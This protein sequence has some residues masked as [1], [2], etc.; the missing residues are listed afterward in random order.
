MEKLL[1]SHYFNI[2]DFPFKELFE[3]NEHVWEA[4][5]KIPAFMEEFFATHQTSDGK[6]IYIGKGTVIEEGVHIK[7]PV[8]IG[9]NCE[10]RHGAYI[11]ENTIIGNNVTVHHGCEIKQSIMLNGSFAPHVG[12]IGD[13]II[14]NNVN[15]GVGAKLTNLRLDK[16]EIH[17]SHHSGKIPTGLQKFGA[18]VGDDSAIGANVVLN[19]GTILGKNTI[20]Y[21]SLVIKGVHKDGEVIQ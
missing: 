10:I 5:K 18:I 11:R 2:S 7:G 1:V 4:L 12:Y 17:V 14:G 3:D 8:I 13:S 21:P 20:V 16:K 6:K 9:D 15:I 19:P